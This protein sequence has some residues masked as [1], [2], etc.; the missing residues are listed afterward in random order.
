MTSVDIHHLIFLF[1][2]AKQRDIYFLVLNVKS[3]PA[4]ASALP[5]SLKI[6]FI[7]YEASLMSSLMS[8]FSDVPRTRKCRLPI[9]VCRR[10]LSRIAIAS[11]RPSYHGADRRS[12]RRL[13]L[14]ARIELPLSELADGRRTR[15]LARSL[16][17]T[18]IHR[19]QQRHGA[20]VRHPETV[21]A[22]FGGC[23]V[24]LVVQSI[25]DVD[26]DNSH[27]APAGQLSV[28]PTVPRGRQ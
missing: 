18:S 27:N 13:V 4:T 14:L 5:C 20:D 22:G 16:R 10:H 8:S 11:G 24:G 6:F 9:N 3:L 26:D 23:C 17:Q 19:P 7:N 21:V 28:R 25:R 15:G 2:A 12:S 1:S